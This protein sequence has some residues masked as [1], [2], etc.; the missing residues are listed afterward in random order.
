M[1][2]A[3]IITGATSGI[4]R[5]LALELARRGW[6]LGL[7]GRRAAV[8]EEVREAIIAGGAPAAVRTATA[9]ARAPASA[10]AAPPADTAPRG[11]AGAGTPV[12]P[13]GQ[14]ASAQVELRALDV[15]DSAAVRAAIPELSAK[16]GGV[17]LVVA[18][19]G[20][21]AQRRVGTGRFELD[22]DIIRTNVIGAMATVDAAVELFRAAGGGHV[23]GIGSVAGFRGL[24]SN[25]AYSASKAALATYLE[26]VRADVEPLGIAVT[27]ISPG[28]IDTP[29]NDKNPSRPFLISAADGARRIADLIER[30]VRQSTVPVF[31]WG[32]LGVI[33]RLLPEAIWLPA[34]RLG[35]SGRR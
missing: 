10:A 25:G 22:E 4:G 8:L 33:L 27:T 19:A 29:M 31:P 12:S 17:S 13:G 16:L 35:M 24:P 7:T 11:L 9:G 3:A 2:K 23:V 18:N 28:Y 5:S 1:G 32:P 30:R 20:I 26:S 15:R 6:A 21:A 34:V 14:P